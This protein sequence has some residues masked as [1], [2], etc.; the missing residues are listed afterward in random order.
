M[1]R[2][3]AVIGYFSGSTQAVA[4]LLKA[5]RCSMLS[6]YTN[7]TPVTVIQGVDNRWWAI[8]RMIVRLRW[9]RAALTMLK[10][11]GEIDCVLPTDDQWLVLYHIEVALTTT[12]KFQRIFEAENVVTG[13]LVPLGI[14]RICCAYVTV[15]QSEKTVAAVKHLTAKLL[16]DF[17]WRWTPADASGKVAYTGRPDVGYCNRYTG[18]HPFLFVAAASDPRVKGTYTEISPMT[19]L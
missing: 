15:H 19:T 16:E 1:A 4:K 11:S 13:S 3:R 12:A 17:D 6:I 5:Q 8:W 14:Y 10:A 18:L 9:L 7:K 2:A